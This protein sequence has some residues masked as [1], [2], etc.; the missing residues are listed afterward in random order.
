MLKS[1]EIRLQEIRDLS[2]GNVTSDLLVS[3][4]TSY[5]PQWADVIGTSLEANSLVALYDIKYLVLQKVTAQEHQAPNSDGMLAIYKPYRTTG[6]Y[7]WL[8]GE[9]C[10]KGDV[11][12]VGDDSYEA[13]QDPGANIYSP[14]LVP[15][16]WVKV[17][18]K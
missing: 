5:L 4:P 17:E 15:A 13:I 9:Y 11:R 10:V 1:K 14:E 8:Y 7:E 3:V 18:E 16:V 6:V 2:Q 12:T